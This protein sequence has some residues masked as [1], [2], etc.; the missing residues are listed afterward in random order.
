MHGRLPHDPDRIAAAPALARY[1][2]RAPPESL[3]R[4]HIPFK[5]LLGRNNDLPTC[6]PT[7]YFNALMAASLALDGAVPV[8]SDAMIPPCYA[9]AYGRPGMTDDEIAGTQ[10]L[11]ILDF[12]TWQAKNGVDIGQGADR[13]FV[14]D[15]GV[16]PAADRGGIAATASEL[17]AAMLGVRIYVED[18]ERLYTA[19]Q[20]LYSDPPSSP[21][22]GLHDLIVWD[23]AGLMDDSVCLIA[24]YGM[25]VKAPWAWVAHR[26]DEAHGLAWRQL[27]ISPMQGDAWHADVVGFAG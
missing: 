27:A 23:Y 14:A 6:V 5:P 8:I 15:F 21:L 10:G 3:D 22:D 12:L 25:L 2:L 13:K 4:S 7:A 16:V 1:G 24:T 17:G 20:W 26:I 9:D 19:D 18:I 11:N